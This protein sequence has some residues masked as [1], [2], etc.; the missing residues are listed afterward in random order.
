MKKLHF[1]VMMLFT[2][3]C[4]AID[5]KELWDRFGLIDISFAHISNEIINLK[6]TL[7]N[8]R[9]KKPHKL[10]DNYRGGIVFYVDEKGQH[11]LIVSKIDCS[12]G[13]QWRNGSS[14]NKVTNARADGLRAG[15]SNTALIIPQQTIDNQK[16]QF[17]AL[18]AHNFRISEDGVSPCQGVNTTQICYGGWYLPSSYELQLI[19]KN[20]NQNSNNLFATN[21]YWSSTEASVSTAW[22]VNFYSGEV[23]AIVKSSNIPH[24]RAISKF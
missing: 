10:G 4:F 6:N 1:I 15:E 2:S 12:E 9:N 21:A 3:L 22:T 16:G 5:D 7:E 17:A 11:G 13:I 19:Y 18:L 23:S 20:L 8:E 24:V 14:G